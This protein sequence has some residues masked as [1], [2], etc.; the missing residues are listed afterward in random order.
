MRL[1]VCLFII[2]LFFFLTLFIVYHYKIHK[3]KYKR[4]YRLISNLRYHFNNQK[5][6]AALKRTTKTIDALFI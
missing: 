4:K 1:F 3:L 6:S 2:Y 5:T